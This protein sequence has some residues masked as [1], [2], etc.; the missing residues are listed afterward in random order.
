MSRYKL[1]PPIF[2][3]VEMDGT[4]TDGVGAE[5]ALEGFAGKIWLPANMLDEV[6]PL[7]PEPTNLGAVVQIRMEGLT[8]GNI[9]FQLF[10]EGWTEPGRDKDGP[11]F[12]YL[13]WAEVCGYGPPVLLVPAP[14]PVN[15]PWV[16]RVE[17]GYRA[18]MFKLGATA[19]LL[20]IERRD[21]TAVASVHIEADDLRSLARAAWTAA[22][23]MDAQS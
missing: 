22:D 13:S 20:A 14:E 21:G 12:R 1:L 9:L 11:G 7:P 2:G 6:L 19:P 18:S 3:G 17:L 16:S 10:G 23:R 5:F 15:L 8:P 4:E